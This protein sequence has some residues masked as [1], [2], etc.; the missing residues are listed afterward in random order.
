MWCLDDI[1]RDS[2][3]GLGRLLGGEHAST[4]Q[5]GVE[6]PRLLKR[7]RPKLCYYCCCC[8]G[9]LCCVCVVLCC[10][11]L[12]CVVLCCVVLCCVVLCCVV[13]WCGVVLMNCQ[14]HIHKISSMP[15]PKKKGKKKRD[16]INSK[17]VPHQITNITVFGV[18]KQKIC[19]CNHFDRDGSPHPPA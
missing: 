6:A 5:S 14:E 19:N 15:A 9:V 16:L 8:G 7:S 18:Q 11:V 1:G 17:N 10:V 12:C 2:W 3:F 4:P 13:F